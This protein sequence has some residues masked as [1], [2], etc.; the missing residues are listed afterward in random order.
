MVTEHLVVD[1]V[2]N[3]HFQEKKQTR[4]QACTIETYILNLHGVIRLCYK[5]LVV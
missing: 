4:H 2:Q 1:M 3:T 5:A